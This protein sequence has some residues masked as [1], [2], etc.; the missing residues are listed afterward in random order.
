[1]QRLHEC[2]QADQLKA[3]ALH[4][5]ESDLEKKRRET[6]A[7]LQSMGITSDVPV[8]MFYI[9]CWWIVYK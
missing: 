1:M 2:F 5:D 7:Y 9:T 8:G 4:Q 6:D 3:A